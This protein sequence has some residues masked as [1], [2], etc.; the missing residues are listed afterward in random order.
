[1]EQKYIIRIAIVVLVLAVFYFVYS[2]FFLVPVPAGEITQEQIDENTEEI[3]KGL[4]SVEKLKDIN[5]TSGFWYAV[6]DI[7]GE[8]DV[9]YFSLLNMAEKNLSSGDLNEFYE[10][11]DESRIVERGGIQFVPEDDLPEDMQFHNDIYSFNIEQSSHTTKAI[12][13]K[14]IRDDDYTSE[15]LWRLGY[16][17]ELE[18]NYERRNE[19]NRL[20]CE[21]FGERCVNENI[22]IIVSG[23]VIDGDGSPI[24]S[25]EVEVLSKDSAT[26]ALTNQ[27]G[28][29]EI[30]VSAKEMEK[31]RIKA[32]KRNFSDGVSSFV[33]LSG[34]RKEYTTDSIVLE[35]AIKIITID[36][37]HKTITGEG[38]YIKNGD[39]FVVET[40]QSI[41]EIPLDALVKED[42]SVYSGEADIYLYEF[43]N[44][45]MPES[46]AAVD[47][48]DDVVG[49][50]GN[51]MQTFGMP[52]VQFFTPERKELHIHKSNPINL[53]YQIVHMEDLYTGSYNIYKPLTVSDME[54]LVAI[55]NERSGYPIDR[56]FLIDANLFNFPAW[57]VF[58]RTTGVW[59]NEGMRVLN[60]DGL[61]ETIFYTIRD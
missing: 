58:D 44:E 35:S 4:S 37:S 28:T 51:F 27:N 46:L 9:Y 11:L 53:K 48:F 31:L 39:T 36:N 24:Q 6:K 1:M 32:S 7:N 25:A 56:R 17:Y 57:W 15:D 23:R 26:S 61:I 5:P 3:L 18:G 22:S 38:N 34:N 33:V 55:S 14:K 52:Y 42:G 43:T 20:N 19:L 59:N 40:N 13:E 45:T 50:A 21:I 29:F 30:V 16:L 2:A 8:E 60:T 10:L 54:L 47:T 12:L 41:Y 49:Y